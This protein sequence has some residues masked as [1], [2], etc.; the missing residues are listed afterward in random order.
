MLGTAAGMILAGVPGL[1][2]E[3]P[4]LSKIVA[5][6]AQKTLDEFASKGLQPSQLGIAIARIDPEG[7]TFQFGSYRGDEE[8]YPAS[9]VKLFFLA[10]AEQQM[11]HGDLHLTKELQRGLADMIVDSSNDAT[12]LV[13]DML[14]QTTGGPELDEAELKV[15]MSQRQIVNRWFHSLGYS[16]VN[17]C[18]KTW[19]EG[20]YGRELQGYGPDKILRNSLCPNAALRLM[21]EIMTDRIVTPERCET[22]RRLLLRSIPAEGPVTDEQARDFSGRAL[23]KGTKLWSKAGWTSAVRHDVAAI[24]LPNHQ[25][26]AWAIFTQGH[27][28]HREVIQFVA[29]D[30]LKSLR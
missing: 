6:T 18:Q 2:D 19:N 22:M 11:E 26:Y 16:G 21:C 12:S 15:W 3:S 10:F 24:E 5:A 27:S 14:S 17:V 8:M 7:R 29:R 4:K 9:V 1:S 28:D 23:P 20:P 30:L 13:V 25:M